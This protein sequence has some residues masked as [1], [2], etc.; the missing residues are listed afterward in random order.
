MTLVFV[1]GIRG[2]LGQA[3]ARRARQQGFRVCGVDWSST[4]SAIE[5]DVDDV[6]TTAVT[7]ESVI[8][9]IET[10]G[11]PD[12]FVHAAGSGLVGASWLD[13]LK[14]FECNVSTTAA[15][16]HALRNHAPD[17]VFVL[18]SSAAVYGNATQGNIR[19][20]SPVAPISPYGSHKL[21]AEGLCRQAT[22]MFGV[23]TAAIRF[24]SLY[25]P[26]LK[27]QLLWDIATRLVVRP[28][29]LTLSGDPNASRDFLFVGDAV[30]LIF[31]VARKYATESLL[32]NGGTGHG[33]TIRDIAR[34]L[35]ERISPGTELTFDGVVRPGDPLHLV[36]DIGRARNLGF[37]PA[38]SLEDG[39]DAYIDWFIG[40]Q[41]NKMIGAQP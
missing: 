33:T 3:V 6:S 9:L 22:E 40:L 39:V 25:G 15:S 18:P 34:I 20:D 26:G 24:F 38:T 23:K 8:S 21:M 14:D 32:V 30:D 17:A 11:P 27:K 41:D 12:I 37:D 35:I 36:A 16:L 19:E 2:F 29:T 1:S 28:E 7:T 4:P 31:A 5:H 13:P 10:N